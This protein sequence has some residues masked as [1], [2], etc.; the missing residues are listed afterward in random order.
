MAKDK[1]ARIQSVINGEV[2]DRIPYSFWTHFPGVD[3][4]PLKLAETTASFYK[5]YDLDFIKT[6]SNGMF[7]V[8]DWGCEC[9][10]S[11]INSGGV[12]KVTKL[13]VEKPED[14]HGIDEIPVTAGALGRELKSA[15]E[16]LKL[17]VGEAPV[18]LTVFSPLTTAYKLSGGKVIEHL[19]ETPYKVIDALNAITSTT[20]KFALEGL[21]RGCAGIYFATQLAT[22]EYLN[23]EEYESYGLYYDLKVL[24]AIKE[25]SWFNVAH[26]HGDNIMFDLIKAYP[27]QGISWHVWETAPSIQEFRSSAPDKCIVGGLQR[28]NITNNELEKIKTD[29]QQCAALTGGK[30]LILAPGCVIRYPVNE[31]ALQY[32]LENVK[33][34]GTI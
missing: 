11:Q 29:I 3:L 22:Y 1:I 9:D 13:A 18:I 26:I 12:A 6:M 14:W 25:Y 23:L 16:L 28:F 5:R 7:S 31:A 15:V 4:D 27:V 10:Y 24:N 34:G 33:K 8:E 2:P 19:R 21:A 20:I 32:V 30:R 17:T